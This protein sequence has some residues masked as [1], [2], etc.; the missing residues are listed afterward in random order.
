MLRTMFYSLYMLPLGA[1]VRKHGI[2]LH[3]YTDDTQLYLSMKPEEII[4]LPKIE[5]CWK[6]VKAKMVNN[7]LLLNKEDLTSAC[8]STLASWQK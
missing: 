5:A 3:S 2:N 8:L 1:V 4:Q 6:D 7:F